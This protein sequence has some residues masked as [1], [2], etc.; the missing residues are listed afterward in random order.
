MWKS[1][2]ER[3]FS[4]EAKNTV[5]RDSVISAKVIQETDETIEKGSEK[6]T[7][8]KD[9]DENLIRDT[10]PSDF[11][12]RKIFLVPS[13]KVF[14]GKGAVISLEGRRILA[15]MASFLRE[16]PAV[17]IVISENS[18]DNA[19]NKHLGLDRGWAVMEYMTKKQSLDKQQFSIAAASTTRAE[20]GVKPA[21]EELS[22]TEDMKAERMLEIVLLERSIYN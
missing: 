13:D 19:K 20:V 6:P 9:A 15:V 8:E 5:E 1:I 10:E 11:R 3:Q 12:N 18:Q 16:M 14:Y 7:L 21:N 2:F 17:R 22:G 4:F